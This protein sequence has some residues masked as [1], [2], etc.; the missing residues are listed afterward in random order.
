[1]KPDL[2]SMKKMIP[3]KGYFVRARVFGIIAIGL[4]LFS[5]FYFLIEYL[6]A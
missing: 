4:V 5:L 2:M 6:Q 3:L 1:M